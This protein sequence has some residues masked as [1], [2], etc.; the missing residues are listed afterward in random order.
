MVNDKYL[1]MFII[2]WPFSFKLSR[3]LICFEPNNAHNETYLDS[4]ASMK[5]QNKQDIA[6]FKGE[7]KTSLYFLSLEKIAFCDK[8][9]LEKGDFSR[10]GEILL[11]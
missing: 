6:V 5:L 10:D 7:G 2:R 8:F 9:A 11:G 3:F 1:S 4:Q